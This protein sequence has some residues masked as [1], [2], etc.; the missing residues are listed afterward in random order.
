MRP[1]L[2]RT[3]TGFLDSTKALIQRHGKFPQTIISIFSMLSPSSATFF[4]FPLLNP[5]SERVFV[6]APP[7]PNTSPY[8]SCELRPWVSVFVL[9]SWL[10]IAVSSTGENCNWVERTVFDLPDESV[11]SP[12]VRVWSSVSLPH[13]VPDMTRRIMS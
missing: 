4:S 3:L 13:A 7:E 12:A 9:L 2:L 1:S 5:L 10:Y 6:L 11:T 8:S